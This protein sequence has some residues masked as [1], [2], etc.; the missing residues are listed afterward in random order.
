MAIARADGEVTPTDLGRAFDRKLALDRAGRSIDDAD[1][2]TGVDAQKK[3]I[4]KGI[5]S[6]TGDEFIRF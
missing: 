3:V 1:P 6:E 4:G 5:V 2:I